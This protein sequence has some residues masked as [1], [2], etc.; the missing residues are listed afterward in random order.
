[1]LVLCTI[2]L[3]LSNVVLCPALLKGDWNDICIA[4]NCTVLL[5]GNSGPNE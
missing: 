1:M 4:L 2:V 5:T 3:S